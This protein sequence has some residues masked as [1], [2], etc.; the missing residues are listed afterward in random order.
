MEPFTIPKQL[1]DKRFR[2]V[3]LGRWD[4]FTKDKNG[5]KK[6]LGKVP[7][8][9][10]W[11][12]KDYEYD[13][14]K[15]ISHLGSGKN[16]GVIGGYGGLVMWDVD[17]AELAKEILEK[18]DTY[19]ELTGTGGL[20]IYFISNY[21]K[22][23][24]LA[25]KSGEI[26]A[27]NYQVVCANMRHP[28]GKYYQVAKDLPIKEISK[29]ELEQLIEPYLR[30][31]KE[32]G[33]DIENTEGFDNSRSGIEYRMVLHYIRKGYSKNEI[34]KKMKKMD[35]WSSAPEQYKEL[36][37]SKAYD[38]VKNNP[39]ESEEEK[40]EEA[41]QVEKIIDEGI[42]EL[43]LDVDG[44]PH[45]TIE[46]N[47]HLEN[48]AITSRAFKNFI[49][50][51]IYEN[52]K[53]AP[54]Q[55]LITTLQNIFSAKAMFEGK[56]HDM[57]LRTA[58]KDG[59]IYV[60]IGD[61]EWNILKV[62][63][64]KIEIIQEQE[65]K[66]KR[67]RHMHQLN[68]DLN[69][70]I[71]DIE[72][73]FNHIPITEESDKILFKAYL[74]ILFI[75]G[76]P[77]AIANVYGPQGSGKSI[78]QKFTRS[79]VNPSSLKIL[80]LAKN[81]TEL[82]QQVSHHYLPFYDNVTNISKDF[83]DFFCRV[84]TGEGFSKRELFTDDEDIIYN[85]KRKLAFNGINLPGEEPD[86]L[87]RCFTIHL[88]RINKKDRKTEE[89]LWNDFNKD[90]PKITGALLK[91][92][93]LTLSKI[94][95]I[96]LTTL[97]R[98]ADYAKWGEAVSQVLGEDAGKFLHYYFLKIEGLNKEALEANPVGFCLIELMHKNNYFE[99][100]ASELLESLE[101]VAE[102]MKLVNS[103]LWPKGPQILTRRLNEI[104][105]N[106]EDE[107]IKIETGGHD[108]KRR[109]IRIT[110]TTVNTVSSVKNKELLNIKDINT[111]D[112]TDKNKEETL[113]NF[114]DDLTVLTVN[115]NDVE[116]T[117]NSEKHSIKDLKE[118]NLDE[119]DKN[120]SI[121]TI[122]NNIREDSEDGLED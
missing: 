1:Q 111:T 21:D 89:K 33:S 86:F 91:C 73:I 59:I 12:N 40:K 118:P 61:E 62:T 26:R 102:Q 77:T 109:I 110:K 41:E 29:E 80:S 69:A 100:P 114:K 14:P 16:V 95:E 63:K 11:Q 27:K 96:E 32:Y 49:T 13:H 119:K 10:N 19:C 23:H 31:Q 104:A 97:P 105:S 120:N 116:N 67:F 38:Y 2:F 57:Y 117:V 8:E 74:P 113:L 46:V 28:N 55:N 24:I 79:L 56:K 115:N 6:S 76:I 22:N 53:E 64:E 15:V 65:I 92:V 30:K 17:D 81:L 7:F 106:L 88:A 66:F 34:F 25:N 68:F 112:N 94:N 58:F 51:K 72:L 48:W 82:V 45:A 108:G 5:N 52:S 75:E 50:R 47:N 70:D 44:T 42:T 103:K 93:Q 9:K 98:M 60:D 54:S 122:S 78:C 4:E 20:H 71:K 90:Q 35:K 83:S 101:P 121:N 99:G 43:F 84:V 37:Y 85:F 39:Q 36:T 3:L 87:D 107:G 18:V